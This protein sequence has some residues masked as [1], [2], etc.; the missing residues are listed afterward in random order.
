MWRIIAM[1]MLLSLSQPAQAISSYE[2]IREHFRQSSAPIVDELQLEKVWMCSASEEAARKL[3]RDVIQWQPV[4]SFQKQQQ[5][6]VQ[7]GPLGLRHIAFERG[8]I[9]LLKPEADKEDSRQEALRVDTDGNLIIEM[10]S[11]TKSQERWLPSYT[12]PRAVVR[13]YLICQNPIHF[14]ERNWHRGRRIWPNDL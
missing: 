2:R 14:A 13:M 10:L 9:F 6:V 11:Y 12:E 7:T 8:E 3:F 4:L 5:S 1:F